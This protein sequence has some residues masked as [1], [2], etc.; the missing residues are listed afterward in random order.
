[1]KVKCAICGKE[2][3]SSHVGVKYCPHCGLWYCYNCAGSG[4]TQCPKCGKYSL[5]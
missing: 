3:D 4:R 2:T 5:K 1:M